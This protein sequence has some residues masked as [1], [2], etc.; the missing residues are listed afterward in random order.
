MRGRG[1]NNGGGDRGET[2]VS[3]IYN[4]ETP[5]KPFVK[6]AGGKRQLLP[7]IEARL[8]WDE[9]KGGYYDYVEPFVGGGAVLFHVLANAPRVRA[10]INDLNPRLIAT[11]RAIRDNVDAVITSLSILADHFLP[12]D[13]TRRLEFYL[14]TR[15]RFNVKDIDD[16]ENAAMLIFLNRTCFNGLYRENAKGDFNVPY[17]KV[18]QPLLCDITTLRADSEAL[19]QVT[20][21]CGDFPSVLDK[22]NR[23]TFFYLDPPYK[24]ISQ[25]SSFNTYTKEPFDDNEQK[26]LA[27]FCRT[28][29]AHGH[30]FLLSNS[31]PGD[32]FFDDLYS[33][34]H[35]ERVRARRSVNAN[36]SKRGPLNELL[37][38]NF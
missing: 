36:P 6:W 3:V 21:Q 29:D 30:R 16:A 2:V 19:Q 9:L 4:S 28:L 25:T 20:L 24:P 34:F 27:T 7:E 26:R 11:Y 15:A 35:I 37:I 12:L 1:G 8:P 38:S 14:S 32:G 31:D 17:G 13:A 22:V 5:T 10:I 23:P 33:G 18:K